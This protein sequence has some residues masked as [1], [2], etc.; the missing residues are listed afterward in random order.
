VNGLTAYS[1][2]PFLVTS[3]CPGIIDVTRFRPDHFTTWQGESTLPAIGDLDGMDKPDLAAANYSESTVSIFRNTTSPGVI[4]GN[5][6]AVHIDFNF[7]R[8][9]LWHSNGTLMRQ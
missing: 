8:N 4:S 3:A 5:S 1:N 7:W 2:E 6:F 9:T